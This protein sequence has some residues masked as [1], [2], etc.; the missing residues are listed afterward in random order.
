M[1]NNEP[2]QL[3]SGNGEIILTTKKKYLEHARQKGWDTKIPMLNGSYY[4]YVFDSEGSIG[5]YP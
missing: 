5:S 3:S 2:M 1:Q 4:C